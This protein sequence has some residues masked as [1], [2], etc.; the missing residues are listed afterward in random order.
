ME[1]AVEKRWSVT[2]SDLQAWTYTLLDCQ[3]HTIRYKHFFFFFFFSSAYYGLFSG[4]TCGVSVWNG[5]QPES[6]ASV[7]YLHRVLDLEEEM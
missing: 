1:A 6:T 2:V 3:M 5:G 7:L 4:A